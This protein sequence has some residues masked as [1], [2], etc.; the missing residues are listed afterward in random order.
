MST[1]NITFGG[2]IPANYDRY[3]GPLLFEPYA[4]D[5]AS[6]VGT[7]HVNPVLEVACGTGRVTNHLKK[8]ITG[9]V[10]ATD[11]NPDM[12]A[13]A[14]SQV[15]HA[16]IEWRTADMQALPFEDATFDTVVCQFGIM[17]VPDKAQA[18]KEVLRVLRPGGRFIFNTWDRIEN[19]GVPSVANKVVTEFFNGAP[20]MF[21]SIPFSMFKPDELRN[22]PIQNGF[23]SVDVR[24]VKKVGRSNTSMDAARGMVEGSPIINEIRTKDPA[25]IDTI[26]ELIS[27]EVASRFNDKPVISPLQAWVGEAVK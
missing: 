24:L 14:K 1:P 15:P 26:L 27:R 23:S 13:V 2:S 9:S 10:V 8:Q 25:S 6:R 20:P 19:N 4:L 3:L 17:F 21:Y 11:I 22:L 18:F 5:I 7:N 16:D 12:I